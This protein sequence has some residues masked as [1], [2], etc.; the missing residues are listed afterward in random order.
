VR[1]ASRLAP[2]ALGAYEPQCASRFLKLS[3]QHKLNSRY[4]RWVEYLQS[5]HFTIK[6]KYGRLNEGADALFGS[7]LLLFQLDACILGF[8]QLKSLYSK[9]EDF[10][11][12][13]PACQKHPKEDFLI[14]ECFLF[15]DMHFCILKCSTCGLLIQEVHGGS[16][17]GHYGENK[18]LTMLR[19]YCYWPGMGKDVEDILKKCVG[20]YTPLLVITLTWID[21]S[22]DSLS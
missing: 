16:L 3:G 18:T 22:M 21:V 15:K 10:R 5:F 11:E 12:L 6:H 4:A 2:R 9:D 17:V 13:Y 8:E 19:E 20:L 1:L 14:Q 7:H